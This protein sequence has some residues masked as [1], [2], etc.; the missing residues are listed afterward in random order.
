[1]FKT[2]LLI[3]FALFIGTYTHANIITV[4]SN[5]N[6]GTG[7]LR[8]AI[9]TA[10]NGDTIRFNPNLIANG[11]DS[12]VLDSSI[13]FSKSLSIIGLY[14]T[15]DTLFIS[16]GYNDRIFKIDSTSFISL[17]SLVLI[18]AN[19]VAIQTFQVDSIILNHSHFKF[20]LGYGSSVVK[21]TSLTVNDCL[22]QGN[23]GRGLSG[24]N[25]SNIFDSL[26]MVHIT[27]SSFIE[28]QNS[29]LYLYNRD[30][31]PVIIDSCLFKGNYSL[32]YGG[33]VHLESFRINAEIKN[34]T[35]IQNTAQYGGGIYFKSWYYSPQQPIKVAIDVT[36]TTINNNTANKYGGGMYFFF[37]YTYG[38]TF[39][40]SVQISNS[41][42]S[43]NTVLDSLGQ[44]GGIYSY[45]RL[46]GAPNFAIINTTEIINTTISNNTSMYQGGAIYSVN[47]LDFNIVTDSLN[48]KNSTITSN[49]SGTG[50]GIYLDR[51]TNSK[52]KLNITSSIVALNGDSNIYNSLSPFMVSG[53]HNIFS[54][55]LLTGTS[56]TDIMNADSTALNLAPLSY[57]GGETKTVMPMIPS[58]A[59]NN[60]N[61][62]DSTDA[63]NLPIFGIRDVGSAEVCYS[64]GFDTT[65]ECK[66]FTWANDSSFYASTVITDTLVSPS[67]CDSVVTLN[68]TIKEVDTAVVVNYLNLTAQATNATFQWLNCAD[69]I[70]IA[71]STFASFT[72]S[73]SG[74]Y[75]VEVSQNGCVDTSACEAFTNVGVMENSAN[76]VI[77]I[78]PNPVK[79]Q[80]N[81]HLENF[82]ETDV[83]L[84]II[85]GIGKTV[86]TRAYVLN[87]NQTEISVNTQNLTSGV[88]FIQIH[89]HLEIIKTTR[90]IVY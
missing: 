40:R 74:S 33:G 1:M 2:Q 36:N 26:N 59:K 43:N 41:N 42:I 21:F 79:N 89:N 52:S 72:V 86:F 9:S 48:V 22:F 63:Q 87:A 20:N 15:T 70:P 64:I 19:I 10:V 12:I 58:V 39:N 75:A 55:N 78:Y 16:G 14:S 46:S 37:G 34:S 84:A 44:G 18:N 73:K 60:G 49:N 13:V 27:N 53:G 4:N 56:A 11:S 54:D 47:Y 67:G 30:T 57:N 85:N 62:N 68:L 25:P 81:I 82:S 38:P 8:M 71:D 66:G 29:G 65:S 80:L 31:L 83:Q 5:S 35:I 32:S 17:D 7:S 28:N 90:F 45:G 76:S 24:Y 23:S 77:S 3:I 69:S 6:S 51:Y 61:P 50:G 88:Y